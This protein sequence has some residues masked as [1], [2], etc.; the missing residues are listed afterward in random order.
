MKAGVSC[1]ERR[2]RRGAV[3]R[4]RRR[5]LRSVREEIMIN[6]LS[7]TQT[8]ACQK[9]IRSPLHHPVPSTAFIHLHLLFSAYARKHTDSYR[10]VQTHPPRSPRPA[11]AMEACP[12]WVARCQSCTLH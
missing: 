3:C 7:E 11:A 9:C 10:N 8:D 6:V 5:G 12:F 4:G 2:W 1:G